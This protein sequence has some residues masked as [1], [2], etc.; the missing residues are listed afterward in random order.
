M[1]HNK[2][3]TLV[4]LLV[5]IGIIALLISI[6]L[7]VLSSARRVAARTACGNQIRQV[8]IACIAYSN[9]N[10]GYLPEFQG[11]NS[12]PRLAT[13]YGDTHLS[14]MVININVNPPT[15]PDF[16]LG[17]LVVRKY[18]T[19]PK[20]LICPAQ[21]TVTTLNSQQRASYYFNPHAAYLTN[22]YVPNLVT[23]RYKKI[24]DYP[25]WRCM[26]CDFFYDIGSVPH[27]DPKK[28]TMGINM[29]FS[30]GHVGMPDSKSAYG[31]LQSAGATNWGWVRT[32]D[33]T[34]TFEY[35]ADGRPANLPYG[36]P[37]FNNTCSEYDPFTPP[38]TK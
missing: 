36:G 37:N 11:Y 25:R 20:I 29:A 30:D 2:A 4:E 21:Q 23:T 31:R 16:G 33:I 13:D 38:V 10:R 32:N 15:V 12:D 24:K 22:Q 9:E 34:G 35:L 27:L 7:P 6:L 18:L 8:A 1:R 19:T 14:A 17:R 5:V 26:V 28:G 3:F